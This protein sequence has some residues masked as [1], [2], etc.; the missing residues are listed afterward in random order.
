MDLPLRG[1]EPTL[2]ALNARTGSYEQ[3]EAEKGRS[4]HLFCSHRA[5]LM[6]LIENCSI[7]LRDPRLRKQVV[8][9]QTAQIR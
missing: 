7:A 3:F 5:W 9:T 2:A 4:R 1:N 8:G 6:V